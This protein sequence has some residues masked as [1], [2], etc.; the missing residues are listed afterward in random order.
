MATILVS[1]DDPQILQM[2]GLI[3]ES[4]GHEVVRVADPKRVLETARSADPDVVI[5]DVM[6]P[7]SGYELLEALRDDPRTASA[8]I[9]FLSGLGEGEDRVR[10]LR[11]G[12]DDYLVKPFEPDELALRVERLAAL[13]REPAAA[14]EGDDDALRFGRYVVIE[15]LGKGSMGT[16]YRGRDPRLEREV[17]LKTIRLDTAATE[18]HRREL[19]DLL[20][21]EAVTI[22]RLS[23][24]NIVAVYDMGDTRDTAFVAMELVDGVSLGDYIRVRGA[25][26]PLS[27]IPVATGI[28]AGLAQSHAREVVHRDL[29]PGNVLLGRDVGVK[30]SDFGLAS[31]VSQLKD[32]TTELTGTPGYVPPEVLNQRSPYGQAGDLFALGATLYESMAGVHP[33]AGSSLRDTILN[34]MHGRYRPLTEV[35]PRAVPEELSALID[36]LLSV[37]PARRPGAGEAAGRLKELADSRGLRWTGEVPDAAEMD[38]AGTAPDPALERL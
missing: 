24:P 4:E 23:H 18:S 34:T 29:K 15:E 38:A 36:A 19:V 2:V 13:R 7:I 16:V 21:N 8:P 33:L 17:A 6:M 37:D 28:A 14:S 9:L 32:D 5:L 30:V 27:M 25:M 20:R 12:A 35:V 1:D 10:G 11:V 22:A 26:D 3:L 31:V